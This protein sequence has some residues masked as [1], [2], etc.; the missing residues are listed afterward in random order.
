MAELLKRARPAKC[1]K[2]LYSP[3]IPRLSRRTLAAGNLSIEIRASFLGSWNAP[4]R[5]ATR[6]KPASSEQQTET[7]SEAETGSNQLH[8]IGTMEP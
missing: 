4:H 3:A 1:S 8:D 6:P 7:D 5:E 2:A